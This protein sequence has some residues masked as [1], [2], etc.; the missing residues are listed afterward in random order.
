MVRSGSVYLIG[1]VVAWVSLAGS[2][3]ELR[4]NA[5][6]ALQRNE[7]PEADALA[8]KLLALSPGSVGAY[9]VLIMIAD[10]SVREA[11]ELGDPAKG[12]EL[13]G[14]VNRL[15]EQQL[16]GLPSDGLLRKY[17]TP[18]EISELRESIAWTLSTRSRER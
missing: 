5:C 10:R 3:E 17:K 4:R 9:G 6:R 13:R 2:P 15:I 11:E 1:A 18:D 14:A 16:E 7:L 12:R 8:R